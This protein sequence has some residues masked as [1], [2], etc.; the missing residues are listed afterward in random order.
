MNAEVQTYSRLKNNL[1]ELKM[2]QFNSHLDEYIDAMQEGQKSFTGSLLEL[3][4]LEIKA[5]E[6]RHLQICIRTANFPFRKTL[7]DR[8]YRRLCL[9]DDI[10]R[11]SLHNFT[12]PVPFDLDLIALLELTEAS[13]R[14][15]T[16][17]YCVDRVD[18]VIL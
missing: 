18:F 8:P 16:R 3:T 1:E 2:D 9:L 12:I 4:D 11:S 14:A 6:E 5:K 13:S 7:E 10:H 15:F 17:D